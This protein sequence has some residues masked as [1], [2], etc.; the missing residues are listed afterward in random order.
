MAWLNQTLPCFSVSMFFIHS[1]V[2][3]WSI[4]MSEMWASWVCLE[5]KFCMAALPDTAPMNK[6]EYTQIS[7]GV[8]RSLTRGTR[9]TR[10]QASAPSS[11][12][13]TSVCSRAYSAYSD[14][15]AC[16]DHSAL[17]KQPEGT[18]LW[19]AYNGPWKKKRVKLASI[20]WASSERKNNSAKV[21]LIAGPLRYI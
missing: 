14:G 21:Y 7:S 8:W 16:A 12:L 6:V 17:C 5:T 4:K 10:G 19:G 15:N 18:Y 2:K 1:F 9:G 20:S 13:T 11:M 3:I